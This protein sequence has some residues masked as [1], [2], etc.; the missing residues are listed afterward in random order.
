MKR[1]STDEMLKRPDWTE[2]SPSQ[3][4]EM[5]KP[6]LVKG[7]TSTGIAARFENVTRNAIIG[8]CRRANLTL[9]NGV[10]PRVRNERKERRETKISTRP[11]TRPGNTESVPLPK[12]RNEPRPNTAMPFE[13]AISRNACKWPLWDHSQ[14]I[15]DCCGAP[16]AGT[17]P[18]CEA[19]AA[20]AI[21]KG[22]ES[23]R[24]AAKVLEKLA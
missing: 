10:P 7:M 6:L 15:G 19:H 12:R 8:F 21:G 18:Y 1:M 3:K 16:R 9:P 13:Q 17:G 2:L 20:R 23:E 4:L 5:V 22:T 24:T 11:L 14:S